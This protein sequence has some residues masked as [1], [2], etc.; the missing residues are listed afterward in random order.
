MNKILKIGFDAKRLFYN[1]TGLG[2][3]SRTLV[4]T[5]A[6]RYPEHEY[7]LFTPSVVENETTSYFLKPP[8]KIHTNS[9][10]IPDG[11]WRYYGCSSAINKLA[12]D[13]FHGL[14]H[15][16]PYGID[17]NTKAV[18]TM[19]DLIYEIYP[20]QFG[21]LNS[22]FYKVKYKSS[23][24]RADHIIS[25]SNS[26]KN[27]LIKIYH[28]SPSKIST[29]YQSCNKKFIEHE[30]IQYSKQY[31]LYVGSIIE[32]KGL[33]KVLQAYNKIKME[34]RLPL[35]IVG[36]GSGSYFEEAKEMVRSLELD[37]EIIWHG[38][39]DNDKLTKLYTNALCLVLP[40]IYEGFGIPIIEALYTGVPVITSNISSLPEAAGPG[41]I[42]VNPQ[43]V[44][45]IRDGMVSIRD[46]K[47]WSELST[48]GYNYVN[49]KFDPKVVADEL[50]KVYSS[51]V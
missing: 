20:Q 7:H 2:N 46:N 37:E 18:V 11:L 48:N 9:N 41:A 25:I 42:L 26:T 12:L 3:Y 8:F 39:V 23:C 45:E 36:T 1:N 15:E 6:E 4:K 51:L 30:A 14:S 16:I 10:I 13:I 28:I 24:M 27:D 19:H 50:I 44:E 47:L 31:Y 35:H 21:F 5:L 43:E 40:S 29:V 38:N 22:L 49:Q 17:N 32:R 34:D 33:V